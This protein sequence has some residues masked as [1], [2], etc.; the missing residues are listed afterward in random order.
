MS[1]PM[2]IS[3]TISLGPQRTDTIELITDSSIFLTN[4]FLNTL[5]KEVS[6][7]TSWEM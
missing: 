4:V 7:G 2:P 3:S 6:S 5:G 1:I